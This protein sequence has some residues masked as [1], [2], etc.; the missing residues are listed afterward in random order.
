[1]EVNRDLKSRMNILSNTG[2]DLPIV[3]LSP[4]SFLATQHYAPAPLKKRLFY[5][6]DYDLQF[7]Y[8]KNSPD[9]S[10]DGLAK[11]QP[12][13]VDDLK[14]FLK[15]HKTFYIAGNKSPYMSSLK[16]MVT[17]FDPAAGLDEKRNLTKY[18]LKVVTN[19]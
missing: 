19:K 4:N 17:P 15:A 14:T 6:I 2:D 13:K 8:E 9:I 12:I 3:M 7:K 16:T 5:L 1:M 11:L 18:L 10:V